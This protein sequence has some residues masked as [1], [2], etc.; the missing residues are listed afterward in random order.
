MHAD[1]FKPVR[2]VLGDNQS[3]TVRHTD[4]LAVSPTKDTVALYDEDGHFR[5][6]NAQQIR[7]VEPVKPPPAQPA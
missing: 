5:V 3:Y 1:P 2:I 7:L 6:L 4:Y